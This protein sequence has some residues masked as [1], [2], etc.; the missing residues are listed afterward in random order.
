MG[1]RAEGAGRV[2][3]LGALQPVPAEHRDDH[4]DQSGGRARQVLVLLRGLRQ[5]GVA[6]RALG[7][8]RVV[9]PQDGGDRLVPAPAQRRFGE[10]VGQFLGDP[11]GDQPAQFGQSA[12]DVLVERRGGDLGAG[13][14]GGQGEGLGALLVDEGE[15]VVDD[16]LGGESDSGHRGFSWWAWWLGG[17]RAGEC[18]GGGRAGRRRTARGLQARG[19]KRGASG[20]WLQASSARKPSSAPAVASGWSAIG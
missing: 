7:G 13:G 11:D 2:D 10:P 15:G 16:L 9:G 12:A 8:V 18:D 6:V 14:D 17:G 5:R 20:A 4:P 1:Q 19:V 3:R